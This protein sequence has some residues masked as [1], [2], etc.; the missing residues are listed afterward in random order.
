MKD[1]YGFRKV[2]IFI[3]GLMTLMVFSVQ[4][5]PNDKAGASLKIERF[6]T[7]IIQKLT[8]KLR[9][10]LADQ[11]VEVKLS[12]VRNNE[13]ANNRIDF[14]GNAFAVVKDDKT[15][16]P[17]EFTAKVNAANQSVED[18][19]YKFVEAV[20]EFAPSLAEDSLMRE[21]MN[22]ISKDYK[23]T[24]IVISIDGFETTRLTSNETKYEG[25]GEVR[26]GDFEWRK[27]NFNVV[28]DA[29]NQTA[30]AVSYDLQK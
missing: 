10:D 15:A 13:A 30:T 3:L 2:N 26:I 11:T 17:F 9:V 29:Q 16:L 20:S 23:T 19:D 24:N 6:R 12:N 14:D 8:E 1:Q 22:R 25:I 4:A 21:L 27:I 7:V 18:I 28:L 5:K